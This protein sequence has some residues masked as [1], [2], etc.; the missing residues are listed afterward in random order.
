MKK[1]KSIFT[2]LGVLAAII[3]LCGS[4]IWA[5]FDVSKWDVE[6]KGILV[7]VYLMISIFGSMGIAL[8]DSE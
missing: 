2:L 1:Q 4:F 5:S 3:Y 6:G 7:A 8:N